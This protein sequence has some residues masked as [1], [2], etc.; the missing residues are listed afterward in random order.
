MQSCHDRWPSLDQWYE[1]KEE[2]GG[3]KGLVR[4]PLLSYSNFISLM[5]FCDPGMRNNPSASRP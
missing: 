2:G 4:V 5:N 3:A 1:E